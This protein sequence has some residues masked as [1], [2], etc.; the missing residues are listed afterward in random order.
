MNE[1]SSY[2]FLEKFVIGIQKR[3]VTL[4]FLKSIYQFSGVDLKYKIILLALRDT[5][6]S[7]SLICVLFTSF[8]CF[9]SL[10]EMLC[11]AMSKNRE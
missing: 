4:D 2:F 5:L 11:I 10:T 6:I 7:S 8:S 3:L 1:V 9:I